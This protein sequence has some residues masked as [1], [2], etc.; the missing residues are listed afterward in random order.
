MKPVTPD[1]LWQMQSIVAPHFSPNG[2]YLAYAIQ[3]C[4]KEQNTYA[5]R[6]RLLNMERGFS[7]DIDAPGIN[8]SY[9][10]T[11]DNTLMYILHP[12]RQ[13]TIYRIWD[14]YC[15]ETKDVKINMFCH[16]SSF[17]GNDT[18]VAFTRTECPDEDGPII[19]ENYPYTANGKGWTIG[20]EERLSFF[21][22]A[23]GAVTHITPKGFQVQQVV[24]F[25]KKLL[26]VG[27]QASYVGISK[28]GLYCYEGVDQ[29]QEWIAPGHFYI[30][31]LFCLADQIYFAGST[32]E[33]YGRYEHSGFYQFDPTKKSIELFAAYEASVGINSVLTDSFTD[34][35][36]KICVWNDM[37]YFISSVDDRS[38]IRRLS[39]DGT[40]TPFLSTADSVESL[41]V[42]QGRVVYCGTKNFRTA[43]LYQITESG[44]TCL[45]QA[46]QLSEQYS[47]SVPEKITFIDSDGFEIHGWVLKPDGFQKDKLFSAVLCIHGGPRSAYGPIYLHE[48]QCIAAQGRFVLYCNPRGS[49]T[50]GNEF[51]NI[52]GRYG[53]V[54]MEDLL[55]MVDES[56]HRYPQISATHLGIDGGSYG[57]F[58]VNWMISH[59]KRFKA[60]ISQR[61]IAN[62]I[63]HEAISDIGMDYVQDQ[64]G[65]SL[66]WDNHDRLWEC[67]PI[68]FACDVITPT[69]F[70]HGEKDMR[71]SLAEAQQ[72]YYALY[73][74][75][76]PTR[77]LVF[78]GENHN[79]SRSG[80]PG[81]RIRAL[82][83]INQWF[84]R[85][86]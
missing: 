19:V 33:K 22:L 50:H 80:K 40:I 18:L 65:A 2:R 77:L 29:I 73:Q 11:P 20:Q 53:T 75:Q 56:I 48:L 25:G 51:G 61:S 1:S 39:R 67:S 37:L 72:M 21:S 35:G 10:W 49:D 86:L 57:G 28:P 24:C 85:F 71:C 43:E 14:P 70:I 66:V 47:L 3:Q 5:P 27:Y 31:Q 9:C 74:R 45:E 6:F 4:D 82:E 26:I 59:S 58:M 38:G 13:S 60:A 16:G 52:N 84:E 12:D 69:L 62:W 34:P 46:K 8:L 63:S 7:E 79:L 32:G 36:Q 15:R 68:R 42:S 54:D 64:I 76:I 55:Q 17:W 44:D 41:D 30:R 23:N 83:E 78:K 81:N